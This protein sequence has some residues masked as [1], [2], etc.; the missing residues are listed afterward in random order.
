MSLCQC[1]LEERRKGK[2]TDGELEKGRER[3]EGERGLTWESI[4][5]ISTFEKCVFRRGGAIETEQ[6][7]EKE[8]KEFESEEEREAVGGQEGELDQLSTST[9]PPLRRSQP[10]N[11]TIVLRRSYSRHE[12]TSAAHHLC[13]LSGLIWL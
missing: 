11:P 10:Q 6:R 9:P 4:C 2:E 5:S 13:E 12:D 1:D 8:R 7:R 3:R